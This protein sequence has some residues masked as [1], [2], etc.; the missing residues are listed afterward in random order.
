MSPRARLLHT[1]SAQL[2]QRLP[3]ARVTQVRPLALF[4]LGM[5]WAG[6]VSLRAVAATLPLAVADASI[7]RRLHRWLR[8]ERVPVGPLWRG[9]LPWLLASRQG[10]PILLVLDPTPHNGDATILMLGIVCRR[11]ILPVAWRV[12]VQKTRWPQ[13]QISYLRAMFAEVAAALPADCPVTL[14]GDR[15]L[16]SAE[17]IDAAQAVGWDVVFRLSADARQGHTIRL[18]DGRVG[19]VWDLVTGPG[20]RW[21]SPVAIFKKAGWR[22]LHLT[23]HWGQ[24]QEVPGL[25]LSTQPGGMARV[26]AHAEATYADCK[27]RGFNI[28]ASRITA[29]DRL[30][31]LL[32]VLHLVLWWATQL[33]LRAIRQG[34]RGRF[35]RAG[36]RDLSVI[37]IGRAALADGLDR[38]RHVPPLPF[39]STPTGDV[40]TWLA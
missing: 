8:N 15:A 12:V 20:Q 18:P 11:R 25:L 3:A 37:R 13:L 16:P 24:D 23:I 10:Q 30:D 6:R 33:G 4:V 39:H 19:P 32:L 1:W 40:F 7:E 28:E 17:L 14:I 2:L 35:D 22:S 5:L 36:R 27:R 34:D 9:L 26:R 31:R 38:C 29:L 21:A